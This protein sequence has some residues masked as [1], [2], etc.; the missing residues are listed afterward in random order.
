MS[1]GELPEIRSVLIYKMRMVDVLNFLRLGEIED[2][3]RF[4]LGIPAGA[5]WGRFGRPSFRRLRQT[6]KDE[7]GYKWELRGIVD[8]VIMQLPGRGGAGWLALLV[9]LRLIRNYPAAQSMT[10]SPGGRESSQ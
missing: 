10:S 6:A 5:A 2:E 9:G 3:A 7:M 8:Y 1:L 4:W